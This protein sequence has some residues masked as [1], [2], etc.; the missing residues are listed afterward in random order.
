MVTYVPLNLWYD[1]IPAAALLSM[2]GD[3]LSISQRVMPQQVFYLWQM[4]RN[5]GS[6]HPWGC[7]RFSTV[8]CS[9]SADRGARR[10]PAA[11]WWGFTVD[12]SFTIWD[13]TL[14]LRA[15]LEAAFIYVFLISFLVATFAV[16]QSSRHHEL[17]SGNSTRSPVAVVWT[18]MLCC[19]EQRA[20]ETC[21]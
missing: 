4:M 6:H 19:G 12:L 7:H 11:P 18:G 5:H 3:L 16:A 8:C 10:Q 9:A 2:G 20:G 21:R 14:A 17:R 15:G 1:I 13:I